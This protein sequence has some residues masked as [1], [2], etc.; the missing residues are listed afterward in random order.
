M[1]TMISSTRAGDRFRQPA[2]RVITVL[3]LSLLSLSCRNIATVRDE[4]IP[5][6]L[7]PLTNSEFKDL[8]AKLQPLITLKSLRAQRVALQFLDVESSERYRTAEA[9]MLLNRPDQIRVIVQVPVTGTQIADMVSEANHFKVAIYRPQ[10]YRRFL[11]GTNDAD[12]SA[13]R[14]KL[15]KDAQSAL[16][17]ARPF[18]F[19]DAL[20]IQPLHVGETGFSYTVAEEFRVEPDKRHGAKKNAQ[21]LRGFYVISEV[22]LPS[23]PQGLGKLRR[24]FW[25]DRTDQSRFARQQVYDTR[26]QLATDVEYSSY[27]QLNPNQEELR[28]SVILVSRPHESYSARLTFIAGRFD[29]NPADFP[30]AAFVLENKE[31]LPETD[32]DKASGEA[33]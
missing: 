29:V 11:V 7:T 4:T 33:P 17:D 27:M 16:I 22:E 30:P 20:M 23:A 19:T 14:N 10:K 25:F 15:P 3:V 13:W 18:H 5:R 21:L 28:P 9:I 1:M 26:G 24:K 2:A 31:S 12:Y 8:T 32:L 6:L